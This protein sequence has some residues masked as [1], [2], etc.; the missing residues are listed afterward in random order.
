MKIVRQETIS[1]D[2]AIK[3][4]QE[5]SAMSLLESHKGFLYEGEYPFKPPLI[6]EDGRIFWPPVDIHPSAKIGKGVVIGRYTNICGDIEIGDYTR[7]QGFCFIPDSVKIGEYV[8]IGPGVVFTNVKY[9]KVRNNQMKTRDGLTVIENDARIGAGA[10]I[11]PGI[12]VGSGALVG[13][14]AVVTKDV[15]A[16]AIVTGCPAKIMKFIK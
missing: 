8:F 15:P 14:G 2:E 7:I 6:F 5:D 12:R 4:I 9:P 16:D 13:M 10:I 11:G 1:R 3:F